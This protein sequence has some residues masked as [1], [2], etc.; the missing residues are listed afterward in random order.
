MPPDSA[1]PI[2]VWKL[3]VHFRLPTGDINQNA[4]EDNHIDRASKCLAH[5]RRPSWLFRTFHEVKVVNWQYFGGRYSEAPRALA[6]HLC[7]GCRKCSYLTLF[8]H[9]LGSLV[10]LIQMVVNRACS[11]WV[12]HAQ[13]HEGCLVDQPYGSICI[14]LF[15]F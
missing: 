11:V 14:A 2:S 6:R 8:L 12:S 15:L 4:P 7:A 3:S 5:Q 13:S 10:F 1:G 9:S